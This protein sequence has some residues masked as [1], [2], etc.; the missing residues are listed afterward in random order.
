MRTGRRAALAATLLLPRFALAQADQRPVLTVAVQKLSNSNS[1]EPPREQSNVGFRIS[2]SYAEPLIDSNWTGELEPVPGLATAWRRIDDRTVEFTLREGVRFHDG[3]TMTAEDV[4]F[5]FTERLYGRVPPEVAATARRTFPGFERLEI[6]AP[7]VVRFVNRIPDVTL[8]GRLA[9][10]VGVVLSRA[11]W[12]AT[13]DWQEWARRPVGTGPY[14]IAEYRPDHSLVLEAH[15]AY[16][17]GRPPARRIRF[18]EVPEV[19]S[20]VNGLFAG[21]FDFAADMPP[22][23]VTVVERNPRFEVLGA[24]INNIRLLVF[25]HNHPQLADP[26]V[27]RAL[28]HAVD[29]RAIVEALWAG[30]TRIPKGLQFEY[31]GAMFATGWDVPAYDPAEA[32][33]LLREAGYRGEPIPYRL[34]N[35]YYTNQ[36]ANAQIMVEMWRQVGVNV[37]IEMRENFS[38]VTDRTPGR[39]LRD[40]SNT[41][42]FADPVAGLVRGLGPRGELQASGEWVNAEFNALAERLETSTDR[43]A[44][45]AAHRRML[46][47]CERDDP[48]CMVLH[49]AANFTAKR[50]DIRWQAAKA[51]TMDF[52]APN[53]RVGG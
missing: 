34:L 30:R 38:Q 46:E 51:W 2:P 16:W 15:D 41:A 5:S 39:A 13:R 33:R 10:N 40:W 53:L 31:F 49:Q 44:R 3:R 22:D 6:V 28:A 50:R 9:Q 32:R 42:L 4:A 14:R 24:P 29:R 43:A 25:D 7:G 37:A 1:L 12:E 45:A 26:R 52:R 19:A 27:R 48:A 17:G 18:L 47:I 36:V 21:E 20:R 11:A 23:Q 8:E 35:N